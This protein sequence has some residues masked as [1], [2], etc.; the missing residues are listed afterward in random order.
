MN[1]SKNK[2]VGLH[3]ILKKNMDNLHFE[4]VETEAAGALLII[5]W[6]LAHLRATFM[7]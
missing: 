4:R 6:S 1:E 2:C 5:E 7:M 3:L